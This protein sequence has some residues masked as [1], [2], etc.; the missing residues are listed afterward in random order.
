LLE[1][2]PPA[3]PEGVADSWHSQ[4]DQRA[5]RLDTG[6]GVDRGPEAVEAACAGDESR[7]RRGRERHE[8]LI[9]Q[10]PELS[11]APPDEL[12]RFNATGMLINVATALDLRLDLS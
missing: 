6:A 2:V 10:I 1:R 12:I 9:E 7:R 4:R 3:R 11:G 5:D 8:G